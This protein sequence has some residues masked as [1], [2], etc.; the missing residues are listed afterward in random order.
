MPCEKLLHIAS[1]FTINY[2]GGGT[3][4]GA[5]AGAVLTMN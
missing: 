2:S 4:S 3:H 1:T 5:S